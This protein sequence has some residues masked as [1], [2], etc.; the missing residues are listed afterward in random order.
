[1]LAFF[2]VARLMLNVACPGVFAWNVKREQ[3][4]VAGNAI[5]SRR[6]GGRDLQDPIMLS[7]RSTSATA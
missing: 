4:S 7:S 6:P 2:S 3:L 5:A 1:M